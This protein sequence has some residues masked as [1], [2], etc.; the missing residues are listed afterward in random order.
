M[1]SPSIKEK[2]TAYEL[3]ARRDVAEDKSTTLFELSKTGCS[4][5]PVFVFETVCDALGVDD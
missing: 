1:G 3:L 5:L 2:E 4:G